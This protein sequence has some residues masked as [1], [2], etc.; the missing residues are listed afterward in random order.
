MNLMSVRSAVAIASRFS[1]AV[2]ALH[3]LPPDRRQLLV[4]QSGELF[5]HESKFKRNPL[6]L[7]TKIKRKHWIFLMYVP[8]IV[9]CS[10]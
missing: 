4:K 2:E 10:S 7:L 3:L 9:L 6:T 8:S 5:L 1:F